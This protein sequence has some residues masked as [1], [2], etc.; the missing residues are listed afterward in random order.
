MDGRIS[1]KGLPSLVRGKFAQDEK[2]MG[3][4][5]QKIRQTNHKRRFHTGGGGG[6]LQAAAAAA[7]VDESG[8]GG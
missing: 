8:G 5:K 4:R 1:N 2:G 6:P 3:R 7:A